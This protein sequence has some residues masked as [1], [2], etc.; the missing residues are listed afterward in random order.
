[1]MRHGLRTHDTRKP[2]RIGHACDLSSDVI[3]ASYY[4]CQQ[5]VKIMGDTARQLTDGFELLGLTQRCFCLISPRNFFR[6]T[7]FQSRIELL[8]PQGRSGHVFTRAIERFGE[9][10]CVRR[11]LA[12]SSLSR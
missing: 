11:R 4:H 3:E 5:V 2:W 7:L 6:H 10:R 1:M 12:S 8:K 9:M